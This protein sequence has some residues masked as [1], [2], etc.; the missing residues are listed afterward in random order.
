LEIVSEAVGILKTLSGSSWELVQPSVLLFLGIYTP[1]NSIKSIAM[2]WS[3]PSILP[4]RDFPAQYF[5]KDA[6]NMG[7]QVILEVIYKALGSI[8]Q[9]CQKQ[10]QGETSKLPG[11]GNLQWTRNSYSRQSQVSE[12]PKNR[13]YC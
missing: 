12:D 9:L 1:P 4:K 13:I 5:T 3:P 10:W 6:R 7:I 8:E 11:F 2:P